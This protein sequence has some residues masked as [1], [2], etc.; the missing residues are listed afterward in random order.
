[1]APIL[2]K[3]SVMRARVLAILASS[4]L[5]ALLV[6][7]CDD[8]SGDSGCVDVAPTPEQLACSVDSDCVWATGGHLCGND[9]CRCPT[10]TVNETSAAPLENEAPPVRAG[11]EGCDCP[12]SSLLTNSTLACVSGACA[13]VAI[14]A[15]H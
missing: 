7:A 14:D 3:V 6:A 4:L 9:S 11:S 2:L 8:G 13:L 12:S 15:G 10:I 5:A 1:M